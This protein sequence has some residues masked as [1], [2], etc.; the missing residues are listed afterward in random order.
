MYLGRVSVRFSAND[1]VVP[2]MVAHWEI[3]GNIHVMGGK[4]STWS[5]VNCIYVRCAVLGC[6]MVVGAG[7]RH[8]V[9]RAIAL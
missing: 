1:I 9:A 2:S 7:G 6:W 3:V 4:E 8:S 5:D